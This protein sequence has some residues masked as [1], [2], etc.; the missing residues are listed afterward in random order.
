MNTNPIRIQV[1]IANMTR[2][3]SVPLSLWF[4]SLE[5]N[6]VFKKFL[7]VSMILNPRF[8]LLY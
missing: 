3:C 8:Q 5:R 4:W 7:I 2:D 1:D 6:L